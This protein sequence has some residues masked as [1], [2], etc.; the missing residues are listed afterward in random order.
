M[1]KFVKD[2]LS[3]DL[4]RRLDGV[5]DCVLA[6][7][8]GM[9][10]N[11]TSTL[12]K[13]LREKGIGMMVVKNSLARRATDG[14]SLAPAFDG[15]EGCHAVLWGAEDFVSLVKEVTQ[16]DKDEEQFEVF[17]ARGGAMDGEQLSPERV[18]EISKWPSRSEQLSML[19]GQ[20]LGPGSQLAAQLGG[21]GGTLVSQIKSKGEEED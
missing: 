17:E 15:I 7:V 2:H 19:V 12:R 1:S 8:I 5:E 9:D 10:A 18:L 6:N 20:L 11:T 14:T 3:R 4:A 16:L 21:P 13:R